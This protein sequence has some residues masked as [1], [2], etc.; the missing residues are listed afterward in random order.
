[1]S[2]SSPDPG[3]AVAVAAV[4]RVRW[5]VLS[6]VVALLVGACALGVSWYTAR[7]QRTQIEAQIWPTLT[8]QYG[9][10]VRGLGV[11]NKGTGPALVGWTRIS[12]DGELQASWDAALTALE[13]RHWSYTSAGIDTAVLSAGEAAGL[14][15]FDRAEDYAAFTANAPRL[16]YQVCFCSLLKACEVATFSISQTSHIPAAPACRPR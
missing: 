3:A 6:S 1:M 15:R 13:P 10:A 4:R 11:T 5:D 9:D 16:N 2:E 8:F 7:L 12:V 14:L